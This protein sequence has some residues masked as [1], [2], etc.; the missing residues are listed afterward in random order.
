MLNVL[1]NEKAIFISFIALLI[2][3]PFE[4]QIL[5]SSLLNTLALFSIF[6]VIMYSAVNMAMGF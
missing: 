1:K 5:H 2:L 6:A 4:H 3:G